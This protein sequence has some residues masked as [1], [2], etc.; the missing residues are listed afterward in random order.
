M[1][2]IENTFKQVYTAYMKTLKC[3]DMGSAGCD[4]EASGE[5]NEEVKQKMWDHAR[6]A[7]PEKLE[8]MD[9]AKKAEMETMMDSAIKG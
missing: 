7:H 9:D 3:S 6:E 5:T 4:F 1:Q 8:G 2:S